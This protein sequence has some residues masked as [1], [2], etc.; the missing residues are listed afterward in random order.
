MIAISACVRQ[1]RITVCSEYCALL[2][3]ALRL[4]KNIMITCNFDAGVVGKKGRVYIGSSSKRFIDGMV[5]VQWGS[6]AV[7]QWDSCCMLSDHY[8]RS[9]FITC[10]MDLW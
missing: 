6:S 4:K 5:R 8:G 7:V 3:S 1:H 2:H 10:S 9:S